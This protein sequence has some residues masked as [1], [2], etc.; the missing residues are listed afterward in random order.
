[1]L[2]LKTT[3]FHARTSQ[4]MQANQWRRWGG[5][6]VASSYE[7]THD[8]EYLA[9]RNACAL[10]DVSALYKYEIDG[11]DAGDF[12]QRMVTRDLSKMGVGGMAYTPWCDSTGKVVDDGTIV[13]LSQESY[14]LTAAD[15]NYHWMLENAP[16]FD[17]RIRDVSEEFGTLALQ[18][19]CS[20]DVLAECFAERAEEVRA[21]KFYGTC[22]VPFEGQ[23]LMISRT[24][25]TG[26]LG[27]EI[28]VPSELATA[29]WDRLM[30]V[31]RRYAIQPAG[32]WALDVARIEAGLI[33][34]DVDYYPSPKATTPT[35][36]STPFELGLGWSVH[37]H[38][39]YFVGKKALQ[40]EKETGSAYHFV[41]L[42]V[43][44]LALTDAYEALGLPVQLPFV[45]WREM[46]PLFE[47]VESQQVGYATC[48]SWSPTVKGYLALAQ[49]HPEFAQPEQALTIDLMV[50]RYRR[51]IP[52]TV[53]KLPFFNPPRKRG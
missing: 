30:E 47:P 53:K 46:I 16:G 3:P 37:L 28:W 42:Q 40:K 11:A 51:T 52:A 20:R 21:L 24:G 8:R 44:H 17:I 34:L 25:Y 41:G 15:P 36:A 49:V 48:G 31:G 2:R 1:M 27:Y 4:L 13:R 35:Q 9:V 6:S 33:M 7:M 50:D 32:I 29:C 26:D 18:G 22:W 19:P 12:L 43:D 5:Y 45:P 10:F 39:P 23:S 14:R 38:K